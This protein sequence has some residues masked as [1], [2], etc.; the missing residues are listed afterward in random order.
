VNITRDLKRKEEISI[1]ATKRPG[2]ATLS[3]NCLKTISTGDNSG[4]PPNL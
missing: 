1:H 3:E 2:S 4:K